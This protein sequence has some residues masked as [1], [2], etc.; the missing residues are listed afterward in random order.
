MSYDSSSSTVA[1]IVLIPGVIVDL[2][3][4]GTRIVLYDDATKTVTIFS[5]TG[6]GIIDK[7]SV[8]N[9]TPGNVHA[10]TSPDGQTTYVVVGNQLFVSSST[11]ALQTITLNAPAN[12]VAYLLQGSF[13][14]LA[15]GETNAI[16]ARTTCNSS[17][18]DIVSVAATPDHIIASADGTKVYALAG[19]TM[20][21]VTA[22]TTGA[23]CPPPL[24]D[25][26]S[27]VD[28][29]QGTISPTQM[30]VSSNN[31]KVYMIS[32][33]GK[34]VV[35]DTSANTATT[36][37]LISGTATTGALT[38]DGANLWVGGGSDDNVHRIDT[39]SNTDAQQIA[40]GISADLVAVR[41]E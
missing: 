17:E 25:S 24:T 10:S 16:T 5:L 3:N 36:V 14:Y 37:S 40:V 26:L 21:T 2:S 39:S 23:G 34:I 35:Y 20:D 7:F 38:L 15:G 19:G 29:G 8:P 41:T 9:A 18:R 32:S 1:A 27:S 13:A 31:A 6:N 11:A 4:D 28:L 12:G 33:A 30:F 22:S